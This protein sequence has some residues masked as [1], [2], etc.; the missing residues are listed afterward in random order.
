MSRIA[1]L[2][3]FARKT[4]LGCVGRR[5]QRPGQLPR[6]GWCDD[7]GIGAVNDDL[8]LSKPFRV[9]PPDDGY[10]DIGASPAV[11]GVLDSP[12]RAVECPEGC[13]DVVPT[14]VPATHQVI[15]RFAEAWTECQPALPP[16][17][18][19]PGRAP[20]DLRPASALL[21]QTPNSAPAR[22]N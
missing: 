4:P 6:I 17:P 3:R 14:R 22:S 21:G 20:E 1:E 7:R 2:S 10:H 16:G 18:L 11:G 13:P 9:L 12:L 5:D 8:E 19:S 15:R